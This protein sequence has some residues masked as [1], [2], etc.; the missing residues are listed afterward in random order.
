MSR[1]NCE[2]CIMDGAE[3]H[4]CA[5]EQARVRFPQDGYAPIVYRRIIIV[6]CYYQ[7]L[8]VTVRAGW[9]ITVS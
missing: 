7:T 2:S 9:G 6:Y 4:C 1:G 5:E 3:K 8:T